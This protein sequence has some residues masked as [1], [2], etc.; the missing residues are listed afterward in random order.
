MEKMKRFKFL[1]TKYI[2]RG[3]RRGVVSKGDGKKGE[4]EKGGEAEARR[5]RRGR[6]EKKKKR[7]RERRIRQWTSYRLIRL[8]LLKENLKINF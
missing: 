6:Q 5:G 7:E 3:R 4:E 1:F 2:L 8:I